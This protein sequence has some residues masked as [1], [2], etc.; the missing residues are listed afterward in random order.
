ML[1]INILFSYKFVYLG[2][3]SSEIKLTYVKLQ[4]FLTQKELVETCVAEADGEPG[5]G[6]DLDSGLGNDD[7]RRH[8]GKESS[9]EQNH[10]QFTTA[11][12]NKERSDFWSLLRTKTF[13][14]GPCNTR[15]FR[16]QYCDKKILR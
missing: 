11:C 1:F 8:E 13:L 7:E 2:I 9:K 14:L 16:A 4:V 12:S 15:H 6:A 5:D 10:A 3:L